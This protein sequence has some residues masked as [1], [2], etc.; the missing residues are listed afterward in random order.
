MP[1]RPARK[2]E[3]LN[4]ETGYLKQI[5]GFI[6]ISDLNFVL[7]GG[8]GAVDLGE[9]KREDLIAQFTPTVLEAAAK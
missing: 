9:V 6:G 4:L 1:T 5:F 3:G 8:T 2:W 7:A